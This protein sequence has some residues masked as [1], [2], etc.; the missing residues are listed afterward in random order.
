[1]IIYQEEQYYKISEVVEATGEKKSTIQHY[2]NEGIIT[3]IYHK[4]QNMSYYNKFVIY[5]IRYIT[6]LKDNFKYSTKDLI[7]IF[8]NTNKEEIGRI[9]IKVLEMENNKFD[10]KIEDIEKNVSNTELGKKLI[11]KYKETAKDITKFE[12]DVL[13]EKMY[14]PDISDEEKY[15]IVIDV[16]NILY[17]YKTFIFNT[18]IIKMYQQIKG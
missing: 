11:E 3:E 6:Y 1:M 8:K 12:Y 15:E 10:N 14:N 2:I 9:I 16:L 4:N 17:V 13:H 5:K 18:E 7:E